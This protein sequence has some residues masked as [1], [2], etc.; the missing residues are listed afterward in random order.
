MFFKT[1]SISRPA[2]GDIGARLRLLG[3]R[4]WGFAR[5]LPSRHPWLAERVLFLRAWRANPKSI[6]AVWPS[7][8]ALA[9]AI[10][11]EVDARS[12]P[13]LELGVGTG[14][15]T[16]ALLERGLEP[17]DLT[18][19]EMDDAFAAQLRRD[20][21]RANVCAMDATKLA[22]A[23]L[24]DDGILAGAAICGLPLRNMPVKQQIGILRGTF[25]HMRPRGAMYFFT[26]GLRCPVPQR[27]LD[28]LGLR[29]RKTH[30][31]MLNIPPAHVWKITRRTNITKH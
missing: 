27:V 11:Q 31:V 26:Y 12:A 18:L 24:F 6:G 4:A 23:S 19:I 21:P 3:A 16:R 15:F 9:S 5:S 25:K 22:E 8:S 2:S 29:A 28:R 20:Y 14:V 13:V 17:N 1:E 30:S 7:S 10:T